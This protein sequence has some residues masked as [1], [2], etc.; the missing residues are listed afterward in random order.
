M[1]VA[2]I[3]ENTLGHTSYL[4]RYV[5]ALEADP[6]LGVVPFRIDAMPLPEPLRSAERGIR[7][8]HRL[9][10][11]GLVTRWRRATSRHA[12]DQLL[13]LRRTTRVDAM[14]VNTQSVGLL[15]PEVAPDLPCWVAL[16]ATFDELRRSPWFGPTPVSRW[17]QPV[18]LWWL[19]RAERRLFRHAAGLLPWSEHVVAA[20]GRHHPGLT[21][22]VHRLPPSMRDPGPPG[23]A[24]AGRPRLLFVGGDFRRKGGPVLVEA[25]QSGL[26]GLCDLD[27]VTRD[28]VEPV[29]GMTVHRGVEAGSAAWE[30]LWRGASLFVFPSTLETFG[31]VLLEAQAFGVPVV[32]SS[33]GAARE[34]LDDGRAG[35]ILPEVSAEV[36]RRMVGEALASGDERRRRGAAGRARFLARHELGTNAALLAGWLRSG[37]GR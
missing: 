35:W 16:D 18:T 11:D 9:G 12:A 34:I 8:V 26:Q 23:S 10:L 36:V 25:W 28:A 33:A 1:N 20:L 2:F 27:V 22:A 30:R 19:M 29:P 7:G 17:L 24:P 4:P 32:A 13:A 37:A 14:V 5:D 3:N 6:S 21:A 15:L 31:I